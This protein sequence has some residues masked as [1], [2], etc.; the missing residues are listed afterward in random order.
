MENEQVTT[1]DNGS[2][3]QDAQ[4]VFETLLNAEESN[5]QPEVKDEQAVEETVEETDEETLEEEVEEESDTDEPDDTEEADEEFEEVEDEEPEVKTYTVKAAGEEIEVTEDDLIKSYQMEAD[6]TKKSQK[7]AEDRKVVEANIAKIQD[8]I[9]VRN[10]YAQKLEQVSQVLNDEFDS[11]EDLEQLR[12]NDPVSFAVK[13]AERTENQKKLNIINQERQKVMQ[14]QQIAQQQHMQETVANESKKLVE[15]M[16]E[17]SDKVKGEQIKKDIRSYGLQNGFTEQEMSAVYDSR[18]VLMLNK[19]MKYDQ[20]MK[21]KAGTVKKVSKAPKTISKGKKI[22]N[23]QAAIQQKQR[24]RLKSSGSVED[25]VSVF[26]NL[27]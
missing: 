15:L 7:L 3:P 9:N 1:P 8:S 11:D 21:S 4:A 24:A 6:Y 18:H 16:P 20:I 26:Q 5:D 19:A 25:A 12:E 14:E 22:S 2:E 10:E 27:I 23:S 13:I 17:F